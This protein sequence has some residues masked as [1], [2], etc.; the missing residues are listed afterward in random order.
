MQ[1]NV[2]VTRIISGGQTGADRAALDAAREVGCPHGGWLPE[3]RKAEDGPLPSCYELRELRSRSYKK[4]T[5]QNVIDSDG[6]LICSHGELSGGSLLTQNFAHKHDRPCLHLD[7]TLL[8]PGE[9]LVI[10]TAWIRQN[11]IGVL[12]VAGPRASG[13]PCIYGAV[14]VL[15]TELLRASSTL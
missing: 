15:I 1:R 5:E 7:F 14:R 9:A 3:G 12:N 13:D 8:S 10:V 4:R 2:I 6:T 11:R